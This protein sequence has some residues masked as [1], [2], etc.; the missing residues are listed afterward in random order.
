MKLPIPVPNHKTVPVTASDAK[1]SMPK[2]IQLKPKNNSKYL[3]NSS[4]KR[5]KTHFPVIKSS[6]KL[7]DYPIY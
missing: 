5:F 1:Q 7:L 2:I 3:L 6:K 4:E